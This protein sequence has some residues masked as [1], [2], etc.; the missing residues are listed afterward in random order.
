MIRT[1]LY[2][3]ISIFLLTFLR[4]VIGAITRGFSD[5]IQPKG[6]AQEPP[7][8]RRTGTVGELKRDPVCGTYVAAGSSFSRTVRGEMIYFCSAACRDKYREG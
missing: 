8:E 7:S 2:L 6:P 5:M 1:V 4:Y 3:L